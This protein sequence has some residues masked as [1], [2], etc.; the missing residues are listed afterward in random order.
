MLY[1]AEGLDRSVCSSGGLEVL[2]GLGMNLLARAVKIG[3]IQ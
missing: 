2:E 1:V 3:M